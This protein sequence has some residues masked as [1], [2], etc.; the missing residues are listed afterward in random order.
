[1]LLAKYIIRRAIRPADASR[2]L[3]DKP[4]GMRSNPLE[5]ARANRAMQREL[6]PSLLIVNR[7]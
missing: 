1:M 6:Q 2:G 3:G 5:K 7:I 4:S